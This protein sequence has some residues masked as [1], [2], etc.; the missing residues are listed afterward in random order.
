[1]L[2]LILA[3]IVWGVVHSIMAS[4]GFKDSLRRMFGNGFMRMYRLFYNIFSMISFVPILYLMTELPAP[5][6]Y[7]VPMPWNYLMLA[8]QGIS[9]ILLFVA[10]LQMDILSFVGL[11]Q[12]FEEEKTGKLV[13][14]GFYR[15]MRHPLY[16]FGLL[17]L[18]LSP[19]V[20]VNSFVIYIALTIYI[21][22]GAYFEERKLLRE[23]GQEYAQYQ[24]VTP[25]LIPGMKLG[26]NK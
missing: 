23:F 8:G 13:T 9:V 4:L 19:S 15:F 6:M 12:L 11:R 26:G 7:Q 1:M 3:V 16:T 18:W 14:E 17:I 5:N 2:W 22:V 20:T 21:F 25:M 10:V 24:S